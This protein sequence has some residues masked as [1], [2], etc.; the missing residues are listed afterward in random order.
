[1]AAVTQLIPSYLG[2]VSKQIDQ[3]KRGSSVHFETP[4]QKKIKLAD[5][6]VSE[7]DFEDPSSSTSKKVKTARTTLK[8]NS[9]SCIGHFRNP[10]GEPSHVKRVLENNKPAENIRKSLP[11]LNCPEVRKVQAPKAD[12]ILCNV[13]TQNIRATTTQFFLTT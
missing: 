7:D 1:M 9:T 8:Q 3:K 2:G 5:N 4:K 11:T 13:I 10:N 6:H 12:K